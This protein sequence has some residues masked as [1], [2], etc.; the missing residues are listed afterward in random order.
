MERPS[1]LLYDQAKHWAHGEQPIH[2]TIDLQN[3]KAYSQKTRV[4]NQLASDVYI[5]VC[6]MNLH[7][8]SDVKCGQMLMAEDKAKIFAT[9]QAEARMLASRSSF[10]AQPLAQHLDLSRKAEAVRSK[11]RPML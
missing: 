2:G 11:L 1:H 5:V 3:C 7:I 4:M 8:C 6:I 10:N 9:R